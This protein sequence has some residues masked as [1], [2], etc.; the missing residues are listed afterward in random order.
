MRLLADENVPLRS[1][2]RLRRDGHD[3]LAV[4]ETAPQTSD[5]E[6]LLLAEKEGR[7]LLTFDKDFGELAGSSAFPLSCG[8]ILL[9]IPLRSADYITEI[10]IEAI[11]SRSDWMGKFAVVEPGRIRLRKM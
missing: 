11:D 2:E 10:M 5:E 8:I 1:V 4:S 3:V 7:I 6:I 9:R